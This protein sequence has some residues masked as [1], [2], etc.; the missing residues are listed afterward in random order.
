MVNWRMRTSIECR[1]KNESKIATQARAIHTTLMIRPGVTTAGLLRDTY[2]WV[3][4]EPPIVRGAT[5]LLYE[6][7]TCS[8][9]VVPVLLV[10]LPLWNMYVIF[11]QSCLIP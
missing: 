9:G 8:R 4:R 6:Y 5:Q 3:G 11:D 7:I 2:G 10:G 1:Q